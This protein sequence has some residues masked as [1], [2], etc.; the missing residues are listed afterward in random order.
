VQREFIQQR[1]K[2]AYSL[3]NQAISDT[4]VF[5]TYLLLGDDQMM[6]KR[7]NS[8]FLIWSIEK[9]WHISK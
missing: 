4:I 1:A 7:T 9:M 5:K 6:T 8:T 2:N 3:K